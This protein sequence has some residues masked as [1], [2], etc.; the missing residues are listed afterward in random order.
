MTVDISV[1]IPT[2]REDPVILEQNIDYMKEQTAYQNGKMEIIISDFYEYVE[3]L[4][5]DR[6][7]W[8][9]G[10]KEKNIRIVHADKRG[11]AY[12]R[13]MGIMASKG[14]VIVNF[15]SDGYLAPVEAVDL[16]TQPILEKRAHL[17][18]CDNIL[19]IRNLTP[20]EAQSISFITAMLENF[21]NMQRTSL[22][23]AIL[24]AGMTFSKQAY[25]FVGGFSDVGQYE[26]A[27]IGA[28]IMTAYTPA[29]KVHIPEVKAVL[30][31]RRALASVKY[32]LLNAYGN[33][34]EQNFR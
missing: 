19:D 10:Q 32:G 21:N 15:D 33:Y 6:F 18:C 13:H 16:L 30:S 29:F 25:N 22:F 9:K 12:G 17:T 2:Y 4:G 34:L 5:E 11:I 28:K 31:P 3:K 23:P 24:E 27:I 26:G 7:N 1:V 20:Q 8:A 14:K